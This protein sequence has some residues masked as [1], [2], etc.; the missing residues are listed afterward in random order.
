M[1]RAGST[2]AITGALGCLAA[3]GGAA[4]AA[5]TTAPGS[6]AARSPSTH[7][8]DVLPFPGTP[9]AAPGTNIDFPAASRSQVQSVTAVGSHSG[10][11][12]GRL[13]AQPAGHGTAF[14]PDRPFVPGER[15]SVTATLRSATAGTASGAPDARQISFSFAVA[16]SGSAAL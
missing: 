10:L 8:L 15:I 3:A 7:G 9:D 13:S 11:H 16:R 5:V 1:R 14:S 12:A 6:R 2:V 4:A